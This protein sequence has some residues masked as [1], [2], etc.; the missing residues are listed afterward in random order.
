MVVSQTHSPATV[1]PG[2]LSL[3]TKVLGQVVQLVD[4]E[5]SE[6]EEGHG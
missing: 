2:R 4:E 1:H 3:R 6:Q 5:Q